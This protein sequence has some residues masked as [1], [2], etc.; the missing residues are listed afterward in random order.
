MHSVVAGAQAKAARASYLA[1][2]NSSGTRVVAPNQMRTMPCGP[3]AE[4][5]GLRQ[6]SHDTDQQ[7]KGGSS[8][9]GSSSSSSTQWRDRWWG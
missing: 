1:A 9:S 8:S 7:Q 5:P 4:L 3:P 6:Q 2:V